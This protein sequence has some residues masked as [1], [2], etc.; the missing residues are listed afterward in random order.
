MGLRE[1]LARMESRPITPVTS[2]VTPDVT[3]DALQTGACTAVTPVTAI[4][5][6]T[7]NESAL[8]GAGDTPSITSWGWM[9][10]YADR[11]PEE[12]YICPVVTHGELMKLKP[13]AIAA[14]PLPELP[15][16]QELELC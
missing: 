8:V 9:I 7:A 1:L 4:N 3:P 13:D 6:V 14:E 15:E 2:A 5:N 12:T 10:H 16:I 11:A